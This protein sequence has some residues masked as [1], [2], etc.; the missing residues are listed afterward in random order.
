[1]SRQRTRLLPAVLFRRVVVCLSLL[2]APACAGCGSNERAELMKVKAELEETRAE[3]EKARAELKAQEKRGYLDELER[4][5]AL[6]AKGALTPEEFEA[7]KKAALQT[8]PS[9]QQAASAMDELAK[10]L[11]LLQSLY[12]NNTITNI[13]RDQK[14]KR[15]IDGPLTLTDLKKDLET[16]QALY[17]ESVIT[18]LERDALKKRLLE[19]EPTKK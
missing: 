6:R 2:A 4:L 5:E 19:T 7:K 15:L 10:Q 18:N 8:A 14:K 3:L 9:P 16:V 13:E 1:V 12:N 17:N 11:R